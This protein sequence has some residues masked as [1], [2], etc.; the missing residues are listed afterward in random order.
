MDD[1]S[2]PGKP[3]QFGV[4]PSTANYIKPGKRPLS[5]MC[6]LIVIDGNGD[7]VFIAG[8][9]GGSKI[10]TTVAY[11][12]FKKTVFYSNKYNYYSI[13]FIHCFV[14][15]SCAPSMDEGIVERCCFK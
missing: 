4:E 10:T 7:A 11:V 15:G 5:S 13:D 6:P 8:S 12:R 1:F 3:N 14:L 9:A 2:T